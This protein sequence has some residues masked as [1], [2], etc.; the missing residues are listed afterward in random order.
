[1]KGEL[2]FEPRILDTG[3]I[4]YV[5]LFLGRKHQMQVRYA[6]TTEPPPLITSLNMR[7]WVPVHVP[8]GSMCDVLSGPTP[9][10]SDI[11]RTCPVLHV[12]LSPRSSGL[13]CSA[14]VACS[15]N[16]YVLAQTL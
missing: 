10:A 16:A 11:R 2:G 1:M 15:Y 5:S 3:I 8:E 9:E 12:R 7:G 6:L 4:G 14:Y 13:C